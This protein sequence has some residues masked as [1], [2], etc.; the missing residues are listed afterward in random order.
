MDNQSNNQ[1]VLEAISEFSTQVDGKFK[2]IDEKFKNIDERF[3]RIE[4][5]MVTKVYLED[6]LNEKFADLRGD[7]VVL[8]RKEDTKL[9]TTV[10]LLAEKHVFTND[11]AKN[12][13]AMEPFPKVS[14]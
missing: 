10:S 4:S 5:T 1:D 2:N 12:I 14:V 7:L 9:N 8:T 3:D 13:L 6:K 11:E